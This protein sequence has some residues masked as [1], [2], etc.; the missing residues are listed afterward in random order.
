MGAKWSTHCS[1]KNAA[2]KR[3]SSRCTYSA[4]S[5]HLVGIVP[6]RAAV[7]SRLLARPFMPSVILPTADPSLGFFSLSAM[8]GSTLER[9]FCSD[10][11]V[12]QSEESS[13]PTSLGCASSA[14]ATR[15]SSVT[16]TSAHSSF[17]CSAMKRAP[18][19]S[20]TRF[21]T[22][23]RL[24]GLRKPP[25]DMDACRMRISQKGRR[26]SS[27]GDGPG[28]GAAAISSSSKL[29]AEPEPPAAPALLGPPALPRLCSD[30]TA[31]RSEYSLA[32]RCKTVLSTLSSSRWICSPRL[33]RSTALV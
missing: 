18:F 4:G 7:F 15:R 29:K 3:S 12:S 28:A 11:I 21:G 23:T 8:K 19:C 30:R 27:V 22:Y 13:L 17:A 6:R 24:S 14:P 16:S 5:A 1:R 20:H 33:I 2:S 9:L 32:Y 31:M 25:R 10:S 26:H